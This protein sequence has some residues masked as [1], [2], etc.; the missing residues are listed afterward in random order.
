MAHDGSACFCPWLRRDLFS[1]TA[2]IQQRTHLRPMVL[3]ELL[4]RRTGKARRLPGL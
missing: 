3:D 4:R 2:Y 1:Q